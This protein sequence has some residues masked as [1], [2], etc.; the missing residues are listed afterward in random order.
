LEEGSNCGQPKVA[1]AGT[2]VA[3]V[4]DM[5]QESTDKRSV[6]IVQHKLWRRFLELLLGKSEKQPE[7][8]A[9]R[10]DGVGAGLALIYQAI[11]E[12]GLK[13]SG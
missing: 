5:I 13:Q 6:E 3:V 11:G 12:K 2:V 10:G 1:G 7:C 8:I 4:L 9:V